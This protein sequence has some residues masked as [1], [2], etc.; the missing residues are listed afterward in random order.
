MR[1]TLDNGQRPR[2]H[3]V[4]EEI[5]LQ[6]LLNTYIH[7]LERGNRLTLRVNE[8]TIPELFNFSSDD[9]KY[10][11]TLLTTLDNE[12]HI[13]SIRYAR[14]KPYQE[15]YE[16]AQLVFNPEKE[17]MVREWLNRPA[18]DPYTLVWQES[19]SKV[20]HHF[21]DHGQAL[22]ENMVR[23]AD[24]GPEQTLRAF[25][26]LSRELEKPIS[27][28]SLSAR[29]FWGDS[30]FLDHREELVR[31]LFP[32][33]SHF[34]IPRPILVNVVLPDEIKSVLFIE[35]LDSFLSLATQPPKDTALIYSA[36]FLGSSARI[37]LEKNAAFS[38]LNAPSS[39]AFFED[40]WHNKSDV[41]LTCFFWGDLDFSGMA[42][43]KALREN[44]SET[45]AWQQGYQPLLAKLKNGEGHDHET[46]GKA[47]QK[48]PVTT[49][50][51]WADNTLLPEMRNLGQFID[52]EAVDI[53]SLIKNN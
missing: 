3:W 5:A 10:L 19:L 33:S 18:L 14:L 50:C 6:N 32:Q 44:F 22:A 43:L 53:E 9:P 45:K 26:R 4:D 8:K 7:K 2:P 25:V 47:L 28:R 40:W 27:L 35:N 42:I 41:S 48:D 29:C 11:W 30:K 24:K 15:K 39:R 20:C 17:A 36:G 38:Y 37:R 21:E 13:F 16:N 52:Q 46:S 51:V 12:Y 31:A 49:G 1:P 34:I 23:L